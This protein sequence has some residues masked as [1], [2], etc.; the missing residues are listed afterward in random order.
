VLLADQGYDDRIRAWI[1]GPVAAAEIE[2]VGLH[3]A[4][5]PLRLRDMPVRPAELRSWAEY[6][7]PAGFRE[8]LSRSDC[9]RRTG[10]TWG[11]WACTPTPRCTPPTRA[12]LRVHRSTARYRLYRIRELTGLDPED[13]RSV[14]ALRTIAGLHP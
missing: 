13:P 12:A 6:L 10:A 7:W 2:L 1:T 4:R 14:A 11:C 3:R 8:T 9:S 5:P